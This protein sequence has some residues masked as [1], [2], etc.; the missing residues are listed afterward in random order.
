MTQC[1]LPAEAVTRDMQVKEEDGKGHVL[2][3][4]TPAKIFSSSE[5]Y[6][7]RPGS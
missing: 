6:S 3:F 2:G 1:Y 7:Q 5:E 4:L